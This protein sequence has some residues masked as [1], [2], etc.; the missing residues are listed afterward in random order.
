M[1]FKKF[2]ASYILLFFLFFNTTN[3]TN[4]NIYSNTNAKKVV[5]QAGKQLA[6]VVVIR[7]WKKKLSCLEENRIIKNWTNFGQKLDIFGQNSDRFR[8]N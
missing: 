7:D 2:F 3:N 8:I 1:I 6:E 4:N 5:E